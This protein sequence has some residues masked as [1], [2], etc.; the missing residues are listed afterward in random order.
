MTVVAEPQGHVVEV[1]TVQVEAAAPAD[2]ARAV[3]Y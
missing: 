2:A 3:K 1:A